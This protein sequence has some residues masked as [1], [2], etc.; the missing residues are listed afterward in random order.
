M[1]GHRQKLDGAI[2][3]DIVGEFADPVIDFAG[4]E[5]FLFRVLR[6]D[7]IK[8]LDLLLVIFVFPFNVTVNC[9]LLFFLA[10]RRGRVF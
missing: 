6:I 3:I 10:L 8:G 4:D 7:E 2:V 5:L 9:M 1:V